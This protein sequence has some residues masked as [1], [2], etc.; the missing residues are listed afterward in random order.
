MRL[1]TRSDFDGIAC[2]VLL[3][4]LGVVDD[5][6]YAHPKDLQD[7]TVEITSND[8]L[9]NVP[10]VE[11]CGLWFDHHSSETERLEFMGKFEGASEPA[12]SA[13][14]VIYNYYDGAKTLSK[15]DEMLENV[16][17]TDSARFT[18]DD[19]INPS[20]WPLL[21][22]ICDP[23]TGL[24]YHD[25]YK[26]GNI[27]LMRTVVDSLRTM[28][29]NQ[30][31]ELPDVKDRTDR[32]FEQE[33]I[34]SEFQ[35]KHSRLDGPVIITDC[36]GVPDIPA[37]NRFIV[38]TLFP[39]ANIAARVID[40]KNKEFTAISLGYSIF[41][42]TS[43]VDVGSLL[44]QYGGGGHKAVGTCQVPSNYTDQALK[45]IIDY[46]KSHD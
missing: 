43:K 37:G 42:R 22:F 32:Y 6:A 2:S 23:R 13:A 4:E 40:A 41:N 18:M 39:E 36:R 46:I 26:V 21:S 14:R 8:L 7:G 38:Y 16:D 31:M 29:I 44:L 10:Y 11:G 27:Q 9:A 33:K 17:M 12:D 28:D 1:V 35:K 25:D 30:I 5:I 19:V 34:H 3:M 45:E 15:F 20:G 24:G